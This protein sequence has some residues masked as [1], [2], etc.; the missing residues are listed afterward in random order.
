MKT[1]EKNGTAVQA[2]ANKGVNRISNRP[3]LTGKEAKEDESTGRYKFFSDATL[4]LK[5]T[6]KPQIQMRLKHL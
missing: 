4:F 6:E 1:A 3:G 2:I 5:P